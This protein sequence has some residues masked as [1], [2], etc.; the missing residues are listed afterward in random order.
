MR[1]I[2]PLSPWAT[3]IDAT[4]LYQA[5]QKKEAADLIDEALLKQPDDELLAYF[6][7]AFAIARGD[8]D[9]AKQYLD[10]GLKS[11][12]EHGYWLVDNFDSQLGSAYLLEI[13]HDRGETDAAAKLYEIA[14]AQTKAS[15]PGATWNNHYSQARLEGAMGN[16]AEMKRHLARVV[17]LGG[18]SMYF[19]A[20]DTMILKYSDDPEVAEL[21]QRL[22]AKREEARRTLVA[23]GLIAD[24]SGGAGG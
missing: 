12:P 14:S 24:S 3:T 18:H 10:A 15:S 6:A 19:G 4:I 2:D 13:Y 20:W 23:E 21:L 22:D 17:E 9:A 5:G 7:A 1:K 8:R 16:V 11:D